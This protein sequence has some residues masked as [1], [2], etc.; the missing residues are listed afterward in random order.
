MSACRCT[1]ASV[2]EILRTIW[3]EAVGAGAAELASKSASA[4]EQDQIFQYA[5]HDNVCDN[6]FPAC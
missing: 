3:S 1:L 2:A 4:E 5:V 6:T